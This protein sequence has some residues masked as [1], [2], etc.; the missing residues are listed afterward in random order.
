M[1][2]DGSKVPLAF[3]NLR[4]APKPKDIFGLRTLVPL[5][6]K[7]SRPSY[8]TCRS[9]SMRA[10]HT[11]WLEPR[12]LDERGQPPRGNPQIALEYQL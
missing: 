7:L 10:V 5:M 6:S 8:H 9:R 2:D 1:K 11:E 3:A 4:R 12:N